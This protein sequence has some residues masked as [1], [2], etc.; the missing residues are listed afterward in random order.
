[1]PRGALPW[2]RSSS[3]LKAAL[4]HARRG[5]GEPWLCSRRPCQP[6]L[7]V[8]VLCGARVLH[9]LLVEL[10]KSP[11]ATQ[12]GAELSCTLPEA[13]T[14]PVLLP[15]SPLLSAQTPPGPGEPHA[16]AP[17]GTD[18]ARSPSQLRASTQR[19]AFSHLPAK[20]CSRICSSAVRNTL[21][22]AASALA[23]APVPSLQGRGA[24]CCSSCPWG[25]STFLPPQPGLTL[26]TPRA[27]LWTPPRQRRGRQI[28]GQQGAW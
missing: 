22:A 19:V 10:L 12:H 16:L 1:M 18:G 23:L 11:P 20:L 8:D 4:V 26:R 27:A 25:G 24:R 13:F 17:R 15:F 21:P 28:C 14:E 3:G 2:A 5:R 7:Q 6:L 9:I